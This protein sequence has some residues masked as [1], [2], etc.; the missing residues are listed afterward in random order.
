[1]NQ[2]HR[3]IQ[4]N[5]I[6]PATNGECLI[7]ACFYFDNFIVNS[8]SFEWDKCESEYT[9]MCVV[10]TLVIIGNLDDILI[11]YSMFI[12]SIWSTCQQTSLILWV[13]WCFF[14]ECPYL[15][16]K[17]MENFLTR[18]ETVCKQLLALD[19]LVLRFFI[20][21]KY[22]VQRKKICLQIFPFQKIWV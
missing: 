16:G 19:S 21:I 22:N 4:F 18:N 20:L 3:R 15:F 9:V 7:S 10:N 1:M 12:T 8:V 14:F 6:R 11:L 5:L 13:R 2:S 17:T